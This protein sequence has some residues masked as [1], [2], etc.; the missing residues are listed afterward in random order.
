MP[1]P[2]FRTWLLAIVSGLVVFHTTAVRLRMQVADSFE[3]PEKRTCAFLGASDVAQLAAASL[4]TFKSG[5]GTLF[6]QRDHYITAAI[7]RALREQDELDRLVQQERD[8]DDRHSYYVLLQD[9]R[10]Y[11]YDSD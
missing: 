5:D 8:S 1:P 4:K 10:E 2:C 11:G 9:I 6:R 7:G 3:E